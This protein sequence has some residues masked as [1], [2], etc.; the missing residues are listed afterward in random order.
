[1][2]IK[3]FSIIVATTNDGGIGANGNLP[4]RLSGDM[5][6]FKRVTVSNTQSIS[7][8]QVHDPNG[9]GCVSRKIT[10]GGN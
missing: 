5:A 7:N 10:L 9:I 4:W 1:M 8:I 6:F 2:S 3:P